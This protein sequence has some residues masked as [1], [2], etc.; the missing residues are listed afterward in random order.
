MIPICVPIG[1]VRAVTLLSQIEIANHHVAVEAD[2]IDPAEAAAN[3][4]NADQQGAEP[5]PSQ[6]GGEG[7]KQR[8]SSRARK[9]PKEPTIPPSLTTRQG[10]SQSQSQSQSRGQNHQRTHQPLSPE[11]LSLR[12]VISLVMLV[13]Y[14]FFRTSSHYNALGRSA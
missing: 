14:L 10:R 2:V 9:S 13:S 6:S 4:Q 5:G 3:D 1:S 12:L 11:L 7:E 8:K